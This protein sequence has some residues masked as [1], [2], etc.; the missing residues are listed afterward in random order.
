[1]V[2]ADRLQVWLLPQESSHQYD[3]LAADGRLATKDP[4]LFAGGDTNLYGYLR[5]ARAALPAMRA[6]KQGIVFNGNYMLYYDVAQAEY[7]RAIGMKFQ[8]LLQTGTDTVLARITLD[9][10]STATFDDVLEVYGRVSKIGNTS[11]VMDFEIYPEDEDRLISSAT[12]IYGSRGT[13]GVVL[14]STKRGRSGETKV[15][16]DFLYSLQDKPQT[17]PV[18]DLPQYAQMYG[19][20][21]V[22]QGG[23]VPEEFSNPA[24][25]GPGTNWQDALFKT[26]AL[27][28]HQLSLSGGSDKTTFYL[29]GEYFDQDGIA[30]GS[31]FQRYSTRLNLDNQVRKWLKVG[32]NLNYSQTNESLASTQENVVSNAL[33]IAPNIPVKNPDGT[34]GGAQESNGNSVQFTPLNPVA[35]ANLISNDLKRNTLLA[36]LNVDVTL[37]KGLVFRTSLNGN[38]GSSR[39]ENFTPTYRLGDKINTNASLSVNTSSSNYWNWNQLLQY[40]VK[41][42]QH[43]LQVM[44]SHE[45]QE[46]TWKSLGGLK[47]GFVSNEIPDLNIGDAEGA[48]ISGGQ[49]SWAME[50]YF[51]RLNYNYKEKYFLQAAIRS[52]GSVNFGSANK[53][54]TFPSASAAWR[55]SQE[56]FM[57]DITAINELKLRVETGLTG[58]QGNTSYFGPLRSVTTPW[59]AGFILGRYGNESLKWEETL[60]NNVGINVSLFNNRLQFEG[61]LYVK[62]TENLLLTAPLPDYLGTSGEGAISPPAINIG[63]LENKGWAVSL[64]TVN[65]D[66]G[67]LTWQTNFNISGFKTKVT[68]FYSET[69][70]VERR[71]WYVGDSGSGNNWAQ[72]S[73]VGQAPWLF[74]GY[75]YDGLFQS[76]ED[77]L[78]SPVPVDNNGNRLP[79]S[80]SSIWV[81]DIKYKDL[82][83]DGIIDERDKTDI[84]NPWPKFTFGMT[85]TFSYK[86]FQLTVLITGV[87]GNDVY[88]L[89]RFN[90]TNPNNINLG[91]NLMG[92]AFGYAR[93]EGTGD[94]AHLTNPD[95]H[96][97][98]ISNS[99]VNGNRLRFTDQFVEDGTYVRI[100]NVQLTYN[101]PAKYLG[102]LRVVK[103]ARVTVGAQNLHT[104]TKYKG[105][106][107][108]VGAYVGRDAAGDN[109]A[110]GLDFG[111]YPLTPVYTF[112]V[113]VDF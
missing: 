86:G 15:T 57:R 67:G 1:M 37:V 24:L 71:P 64:N 61:D 2:G 79:A 92:E 55:I 53:W 87:Y 93:V 33:A 94:Q 62:K 101:V 78:N 7:F 31:N 77:I 85:N 65:V 60:T 82:N 21:R 46:S 36:G 58:N 98:R 14:I 52:D 72:R 110:I 47:T 49:G 81:G 25:L 26:A 100:K 73:S 113:G 45:A 23:E 96:I 80:P 10:K 5:M 50:S 68:K 29:S 89:L 18:L 91:R 74:Q 69:A 20:I 105:Y 30:L 90:N 17:L 16:Y 111:R 95:A 6:R 56:P 88:N 109:Q 97:P 42:G 84:G 75:L 54:G 34:W 11:F 9:F 106:D 107:P 4:I 108:E 99:N 43:D 66:R 102:T 104:F 112:S 22:A 3:E 13:N 38:V 51:G 8:D 28:K 76:E 32:A 44:V 59:G 41:F 48:I 63:A 35:I 70:F 19:E 39:Q 40:S 83:G 12:A 103:A 27:Q